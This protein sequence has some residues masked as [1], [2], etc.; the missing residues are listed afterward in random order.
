[1]TILEEMEIRPR[2]LV[3]ETHG[4]YD[5]PKSEVVDR[6]ENTGYD[7]QEYGVAEERIAEYCAENGIYVQAANTRSSPP[8]K[9]ER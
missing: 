9:P 1:M 2:A 4:I 6:M 7:V 3:V 5:A 8:L